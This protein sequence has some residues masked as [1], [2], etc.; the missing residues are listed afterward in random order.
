MGRNHESTLV[1]GHEGHDVA[2]RR[3]QHLLTTRHESLHHVGHPAEK[4]ALDKAL[5]A[6][7]GDVGA[8]PRLHGRQVRGKESFTDV[9]R[10]RAKDLK[11]RRRRSREGEA[12]GYAYQKAKGMD[13]IYKGK[14]SGRGTVRLDWHACHSSLHHLSRHHAHATSW[15][16][17]EGQVKQWLL[18]QWARNRHR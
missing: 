7:M 1:E 14:W 18:P 10:A 12:V 6:C 17:L 2:I 13:A 16:L 8:I 11:R 15:P 3:H 4:A 9:G 5:H